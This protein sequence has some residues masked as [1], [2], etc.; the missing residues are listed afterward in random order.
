MYL[1]QNLLVEVR[2]EV[3][4]RFWD[5]VIGMIGSS[6]HGRTGHRLLN[7]GHIQRGNP[8]N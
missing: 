6:V 5:V 4:Y 1:L 2:Y 3:S 8:C 7:R